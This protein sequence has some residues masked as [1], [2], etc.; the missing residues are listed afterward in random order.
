MWYTLRV[1]YTVYCASY[2]KNLDGGK[3][4]QYTENK[5]LVRKKRINRCKKGVQTVENGQLKAFLKSLGVKKQLTPAVKARRKWDKKHLR[6]ISCKL[7]VEEADRFLALCSA[8]GQSQYAALQTMIR[9]SLEEA[10]RH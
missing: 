10:K 5:L 8:Y 1:G 2:D 9:R 4:I 6:T 3:G 7:P